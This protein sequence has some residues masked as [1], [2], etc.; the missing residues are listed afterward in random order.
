M[1][2]TESMRAQGY[3][4][5]FKSYVLLRDKKTSSGARSCSRIIRRASKSRRKGLG[6]SVWEVIDGDYYLAMGNYD[7]AAEAYDKANI[8]DMT[9]WTS[10]IITFKGKACGKSK[11]PS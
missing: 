9:N 1:F 5:L 10:L 7:Q 2:S 6:R 11:R 8:A 4:H 3:Y